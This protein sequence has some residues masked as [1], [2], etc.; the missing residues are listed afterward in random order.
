MNPERLRQIQDLYNSARELEPQ[1]RE[2]FL[3]EV[4]R[5]DEELRREVASLL[6]QDGSEGPL[7]QPVRKVAAHLLGDLPKPQLAPGAELGPYQILSRLGEGGMG[8]VYKARDMRL[9]RTVAIKTVNEEFTGRFLR[10]A[11][12]IS[13]L[14]HSHICALYDIGTDYLVMEL[15]EGE[16]LA[17]R[18]RKGRL[19]MELVLQFGAEMADALAAAHAKGIIHRDLKPA[20]IMVTDAGIKVLD[21]GLAKFVPG[22]RSDFAEEETATASQ[23]IVGTPAYMAPEQLEGKECD[24]RTDIFTLGLVLYEMATGS[25]AFA[26]DSRAALIAEIMHCEPALGELSPPQFAHVVECCLEKDPQN[27]WQTTHDVALELRWIKE[28]P[29][30]PTLR[31]QSSHSGRRQW[32]AWLLMA[33]LLAGV[34]SLS[35]LYSRLDHPEAP[36]VEFSVTPPVEAAAFAMDVAVAVSPDGSYLAL[37]AVG[38]D[39]KESLW[40]RPMDS[41]IARQLPGT[42]GA[43]GFF[44]SPDNRSIAFV[45]AGKLRK[46][47]IRGG[48]AVALCD[49]PIAGI[50]AGGTWSRD[51]A[52]LFA[53]AGNDGLYRVSQDGG[54]VE[55]VTEVDPSLHEHHLGPRFLPDGKRFLFTVRSDRGGFGVHLGSLDRTGTKL[56]IQGASNGF[57]TRP[58]GSSQ[59]YILFE[60]NRVLMAQR[61]DE[62]RQQILGAPLVVSNKRLAYWRAF[63][64]SENGVLAY[65]AGSPD[66]VLVWMNRMGKII[67]SLTVKGDYRQISLSPDESVVAVGKM[68]A[69][70][71]NISN[72]WLIELSRGT[73]TRL[74]SV[75]PNDWYPVWS[76]DGRRIAFS[77]SRDGPYNLYVRAANGAGADEALLKSDVTKWASSWSPDGRFL[78]YSALHPK[79]RFDIWILPMSGGKPFPFLQTEYDEI[80]PE[81][82]PDG[83]W[84]AYTSNESGRQEIYVREF[85]AGPAAGGARRISIEGGSHPKWR[86]DGRELFYLSPDRNLMSVEAGASLVLRAGPPRRLF[87]TRIQMAD[88]LESYAVSSNGQRFLV[89]TPAEEAESGP[90][91]VIANWNPGPKR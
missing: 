3:V 4:C 11:R 32:A 41:S 34:L 5:N 68:E 89:N 69:D 83:H 51:G 78:A 2:S 38:R 10:E 72:I 39:G 61:F 42:D 90:V 22:H 91:T 86:R 70:S 25:R 19:P 54:A 67:E 17:T 60:R 75:P 53:P 87:Q 33:G 46:I 43:M 77:S 28:E 55:R 24:A 9:G 16:T 58:R 8:T 81:F 20:N 27:R 49:F 79:T 35:R 44:W 50:E 31:R 47:D 45:A 6:V 76:P 15:M 84:I 48:P 64:A 23:A 71:S 65:R 30:Q 40:V 21:F 29:A 36:T 26:G 74:T 85:A 7:D 59:G 18:L 80:H 52:I 66:C 73:L 13:A 56:L 82:S 57:Y 88:F 62:G 37:R 14:N 63:S 1:E 12:A